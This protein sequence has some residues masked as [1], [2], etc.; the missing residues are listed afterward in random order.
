MKDY[1]ESTLFNV[2]RYHNFQDIKSI[3]CIS[4]L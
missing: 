3:K 1:K 4:R 2:K